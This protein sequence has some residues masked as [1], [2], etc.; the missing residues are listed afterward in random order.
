[1]KKWGKRAVI[2]GLILAILLVGGE[3][4]LRLLS[5]SEWMRK[6][7]V[8]QLSESVNRE[9]QVDQMAASLRGI[10]L[11]NVLIANEGG[12]EK[13]IMF[14]IEKVRVRL[15][16]WHLLH[17][18]VKVRSVVIWGVQLHISRGKDG[19]LNIAL[20]DES[21]TNSVE[22]SQEERSVPFD[23]T[24]S[25][26][27]L[28][29]VT[30]SYKDEGLSLYTKVEGGALQMRNFKWNKP[31]E[32]HLLLPVFYQTAE[33]STS[34]TLGA[35]G[36]VHL[37]E[38]DATH[39]KA[40][41]KSITLRKGDT[42]AALSGTV[43]DFTNPQFNLKFTAKNISDQTAFPFVSGLPKFTLDQ[44]DFDAAGLLQL[45]KNQ[46][47]FSSL[48][49]ALPGTTLESAGV[50]NYAPAVQVTGKG[51]L[52]VNGEELAKGFSWVRPYA[53][54][55]ELNLQTEATEKEITADLQLREGAFFM[56][57]AGHFKEI[58]SSLTC[59]EE[60]SW[61]KGEASFELA[62]LFNKEP[63]AAKLEARQT[64]QQITLN[65][66]G[67]AKK[68]IL[69]I[70][71]NAEEEDEEELA[72][73]F[74]T[75]PTLASTQGA[76]WPLAPIFVKADIK[77]DSL[78]S[79]YLY[80]TDLLFKADMES[81]TPDL[82][83]AHGTVSLHVGEG[84]IKDLYH[85]TDANAL[86]KVLFLSLNVVEKVFNSLNVLSVLDGLTGDNEDASDTVLQTVE[87]PDGQPIQIAVPAKKQK[88]KGKM[89]FDKFITDIVFTRGVASIKDGSFVSDMMSFKLDGTT[90]FNTEK[91]DLTVRAAPGKHEVDGILPLTLRIGG[92]MTDPQ[93]D[94]SVV[95]SVSALVTQ[96]VT[97]NVAS[98]T[99]KKGI[100]GLW[101]IFKKKGA[102]AETSA[103]ANPAEEISQEKPA[104]EEATAPAL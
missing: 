78:D 58:N 79:R 35:V 66:S 40:D 91:L 17:G 19:S 14:A 85:L 3:L 34:F 28:E 46:V 56:P 9:V 57:N 23:L 62:G 81:L 70:P 96:G 95:G 87:G 99:V 10:W 50:V 101:G 29:D 89:N 15:A 21:E 74:D 90:D 100:S 36:H 22:P 75:H 1:M 73:D 59:R 2:V 41:F 64:P 55:G 31:V 53:P 33:K 98:R 67:N 26:L 71:A 27:E 39:M 102:P 93:G 52:S 16:W 7:V 44:L 88:V 25:Q 54:K 6:Q 47:R 76:S 86:T 11:D 83:Q 49:I 45:A 32:V 104:A 97:N 68:I 84:K 4:T 43:Q 37:A 80:G 103:E 20:G 48:K 69:P 77:V 42:F 65:I 51:T 38:L 8:E 13:G 60:T 82:K 92:T 18:H 5:S 72:E 30:L 94:M 61:D 24:I 63:L 12:F